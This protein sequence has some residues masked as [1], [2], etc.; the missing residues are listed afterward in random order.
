MISFSAADAIRDPEIRKA[1]Q[2]SPL[3]AAADGDLSKISIYPVFQAIVDGDGHVVCH[4][5]LTRC[6]IGDKFVN[7]VDL[8]RDADKHGYSQ[9]LFRGVLNAAMQE[10]GNQPL[11]VNISPDAVMDDRF[12]DTVFAASRLHGYDLGK[13]MVE[14]TEE[15]CAAGNMALAERIAELKVGLGVRIAQDDIQTDDISLER[16]RYL[17]VDYVKTA[18][19]LLVAAGQSEEDKQKL[20]ELIELCHSKGLPVIVEGI[21]NEADRDLVKQLGGDY[22]QGFHFSRPAPELLPC[23]RPLAAVQREADPLGLETAVSQSDLSRLR[24]LERHCSQEAVDA[25]EEEVEESSISL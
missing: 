21:E 17:P 23:T 12:R 9:D 8:Y 7:P 3:F 6:K 15:P 24:D 20:K 16:L 2:A 22:M 10:A 1:V 19:E 5:V 14:I 13:L 11:W 25:A 4:E 18:R